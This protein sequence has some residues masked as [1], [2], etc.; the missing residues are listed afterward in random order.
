MNDKIL[1]TILKGL[2]IFVL[3]LVVICSVLFALASIAMLFIPIR[4]LF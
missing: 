4:D 1:D 3:A 2:M